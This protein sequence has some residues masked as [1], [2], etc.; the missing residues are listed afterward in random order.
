MPKRADLTAQPHDAI[1]KYTFS[2]R[3]HAAGLLRAA[4][5]T[6]IVGAIRWGTLGLEKVH[7]VD[8]GLRGRQADLLFSAETSAERLYVYVLLEHQSKVESLMIFRMGAYMWRHWEQLVRDEPGR[9][10]LPPIIPVLIH[11]SDTGWTAPTCFE[12]VILTGEPLRAAALPYVPRFQMKLVDV[13]RGPSGGL[14]DAA[15]TALG[16]VVLWCLSVAGDAKRFQAELD[17]M[18]AELNALF[19]APAD[20]D[21]LIAV[22]R[23]LVATHPKLSAAKITKMLETTARKGQ[24]EVTMDVLDELKREGRA[25]GRAEGRVKGR[26]EGAA[27]VLLALLTAR[28]GAVPADARERILAATEPMLTRWSLRVLTAPTLA[29]VLGSATTAKPAKKP[30]SPARRQAAGKRPRG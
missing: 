23:Y 7:F 29:A 12:D 16:R 13:S 20:V 11:H 25:E 1:I 26:V 10:T 2:Q 24:K 22:L 8:R 18:V 6:E 21:A 15:L 4:L 28:F 5:P 3:E 14:V 17:G 9:K 30:S 27:R 19:A